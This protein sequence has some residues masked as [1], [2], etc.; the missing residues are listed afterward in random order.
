MKI[1]GENT[2][3]ECLIYAPEISGAIILSFFETRVQAGFPSP[4]DDYS[5]ERLDL[6]RKLISNPAN[7][8][9]VKVNGES[10]KGDGIG[11]GDLLIVDRSA[12]PKDNSIL[13]CFIDGEFTLKRIKRD[14]SGCY[15]IPSNPDFKPIPVDPVSDLRIWGVVT[16]SIKKQ[17]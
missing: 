1:T 15:L 13:V 3:L 7:T 2:G 12:F 17:Y 5:E 11:N 10:M 6:N 16:Y 14:K 4:A 9:Y 8:F